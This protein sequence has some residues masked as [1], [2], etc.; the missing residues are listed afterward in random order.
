MTAWFAQY[1]PP[2]TNTVP[3][4]PKAPIPGINTS[5]PKNRK[6]NTNRMITKKFQYG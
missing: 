3:N 4:T 1:I 6:P 2:M 5:N